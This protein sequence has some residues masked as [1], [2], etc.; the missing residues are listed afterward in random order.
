IPAIRIVRSH[1]IDDDLI[2]MI[3]LNSRLSEER[4]LDIRV[5]IATNEQGLN[6]VQTLIHRMGGTDAFQL[7]VDG[8]LSYTLRRVQHRIAELPDTSGSF[9]T[10]LDDDGTGEGDR[11]P[12]KAKVYR[13]RKKLIID[14][15][16]S[17][18]QSRG[19]L[20][21]SESAL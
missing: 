2:S 19:G 14:L 11:V 20:N 5:Q 12:L 8:V 1:E 3:A 4:A 15:A 7:A 21:V 18:P 10:W 17:G 16:G 6:A 13:H 9:T